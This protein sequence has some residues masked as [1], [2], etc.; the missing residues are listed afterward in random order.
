[1]VRLGDW[2]GQWR[3]HANKVKLI[4]KIVNSGNAKIEP[5]LSC[6]G[7]YNWLTRPNG[8]ISF[9]DTIKFTLNR[10]SKLLKFLDLTCNQY[11]SLSRY[12]SNKQFWHEV[13]TACS[14]P[15]F[16]ER[17]KNEFRFF[18]QWLI[19]RHYSVAKL[20]RA[21]KSTRESWHH[22]RQELKEHTG[23]RAYLD[24]WFHSRAILELNPK[25][26]F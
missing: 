9:F 12:R 10:P 3:S 22:L 23:I 7:Q 16:L 14:K 4:S 11:I 21:P 26:H 8:R 1:M 13:K 25:I 19:V 15:V 20:D 17:Q 2:T 18:Y 5:V 6:S 24:F